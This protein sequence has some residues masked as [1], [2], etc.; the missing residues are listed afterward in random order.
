M[1][2]G[3]AGDGT[4]V[5]GRWSIP[6]LAEENADE[7]PEFVVSTAAEGEAQRRAKA[8]VLASGKPVGSPH[9]SG[10]IVFL[11]FRV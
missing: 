2:K 10:S 11:G 9:A 6:Y 8:A 1:L 3:A 7:D 4:A 5:D